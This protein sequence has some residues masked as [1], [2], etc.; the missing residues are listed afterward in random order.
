MNRGLPI[1]IHLCGPFLL[2]A[3]LFKNRLLEEQAIARI[4]EL[5]GVVN[6]TGQGPTPEEAFGI[7]CR[8]DCWP[9]EPAVTMTGRILP[10]SLQ[11]T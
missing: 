10:C 8:N 11:R 1:Q 2:L 6:E 3:M 9:F 5:G 7:R 4:R